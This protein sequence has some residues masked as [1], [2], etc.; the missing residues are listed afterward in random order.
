MPI[1][2]VTNDGGIVVVTVPLPS[3]DEAS[4]GDSLIV[5]MDEAFDDLAEG[6]SDDTETFVVE[7]AFVNVDEAL[8][9]VEGAA[10]PFVFVDEFVMARRLWWRGSIG[11][12]VLPAPQRPADDAPLPHEHDAGWKGQHDAHQGDDGLR[13]HVHVPTVVVRARHDDE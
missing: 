2:F 1:K 10:D 6:S 13:R 8:E 9:S 7:E 4:S 3:V 12:T 11:I 5:V